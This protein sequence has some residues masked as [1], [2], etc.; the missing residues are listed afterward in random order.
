MSLYRLLLMQNLRIKVPQPYEL[1]RVYNKIVLWERTWRTL[2]TLTGS[3]RSMGPLNF[4]VF[5][6]DLRHEAFEPLVQ[7][8]AALFCN[9]SAAILAESFR[10]E[11]WTAKLLPL[12]AIQSFM[13]TLVRPCGP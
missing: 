3:D 13:D 5:E 6:T 7:V 9:L 10:T 11:F 12:P 2:G 8:L 4:R 1:H